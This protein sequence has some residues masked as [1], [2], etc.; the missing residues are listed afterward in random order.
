MFKPML[1]VRPWA[2]ATAL[3]VALVLPACDSG[4]PAAPFEVDGTGDVNGTLYYDLDRDG[5]FDPFAGDR[6]LS[7]IDVALRVR[8]TDQVLGS[9]TT[10]A[11][12][13]FSFDG[14][15]VGTHDLFVAL[16]D[17]L[18][19]VC[20]NPL[21][22]SVYVNETTNVKVSGQESCLVSIAEAREQ[23]VDAPVTVR[24]VVTVAPGNIS[25]SY[26]WIMDETGGAKIFMSASVQQGD[27]VEVS[28]LVEVFSGEYEISRGTVT[29]LGTAPVP[30][31]VL[32]SGA[33]LVSHEYQGSLVEVDGL[34]VTSV[35]TDQSGS[36][37]VTVSAPDGSV[38]VI[39]VD[40]DAGIAAGSFVEGSTYDV[41][42][43]VGPFGG[44]EQLYVRSNADIQPGG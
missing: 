38:F 40:S 43:V 9:T 8:G 41:T 26:F 5:T 22:V 1:R 10:G 3:A 17:S 25:P 13:Q 14:V 37:N 33:E 15:E 34:T 18:G 7:D 44:A 2:G 4:D 36:Y 30:D 20:Q 23:P 24:G 35:P 39:R 11:N 32:I 12:G 21:P 16:P 19:T 31:P 42:G 28:G 27:F 6:A 29:V